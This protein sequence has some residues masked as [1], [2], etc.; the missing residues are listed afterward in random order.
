MTS[1]TDLQNEINALGKELMEKQQKLD[2]LRRS[3]PPEPVGEYV[4]KGP[5][6]QDV[7]FADLFGDHQDLLV[8]HNMGR[9][10][11]YCTLWA[12]GFNGVVDHLQN[13]AAFVVVSPDTPE[14]QQAFAASRGWRFRMLSNGDSGFTEAMGYMPEKDGKRHPWPG[15][16]AFR[17]RE[18]GS[19]VRTAHSPLGPGD[20]YCA[21]WHLFALFEGG[22]GAWQPKFSYA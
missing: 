21:V 1:T 9:Q 10:C 16:S 6:D 20:P 15:V 3:L 14:E 17:K 2:E 7:P 13:R 11:P 8:I 12:D 19:V 4:L 22:V 18:D 5:N